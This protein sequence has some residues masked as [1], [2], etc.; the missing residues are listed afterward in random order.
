MKDYLVE[1]EFDII[2][3]K[4]KAQ[5]KNSARKKALDKLKKRNPVSLIKTAFYTRKKQ[6]YVDEV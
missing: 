1:I 3:I 6:I 5:N 2:E 4:V